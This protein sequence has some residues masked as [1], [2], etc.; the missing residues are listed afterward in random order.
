[1]ETVGEC[2]SPSELESVL[3]KLKSILYHTHYMI[4]QVKIIIEAYKK[5]I[6]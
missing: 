2:P 6:C 4:L 1:M 3:H 5:I